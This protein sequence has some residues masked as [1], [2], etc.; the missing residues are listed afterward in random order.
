MPAERIGTPRPAVP[1]A[2]L[3]PLLESAADTLRGLEAN[4]VPASLRHLHGFDSRGLDARPRA[5][6]ASPSVRRRCCLSRAVS[7]R[8]STAARTSRRAARRSGWRTRRGSSSRRRPHAATCRCSRRCCGRVGRS[9]PTSVSGLSSRSTPGTD[10]TM[11]NRTRRGRRV[12]RSPSWRRPSGAPT[13]RVPRR[14]PKPRVER[15][16]AQGASQPP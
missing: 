9:A 5:A 4:D 1:D 8:G 10:A 16:V 15:G 13:R 2:L 7:W 6:S 11:T 3:T 12:A 14:R